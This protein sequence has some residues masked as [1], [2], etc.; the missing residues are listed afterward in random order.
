MCI[1][2]L[3][4]ADAYF[5]GF[6]LHYIFLRLFGVPMVECISMLLYRPHFS[7]LVAIESIMVALML[8]MAL[9]GLFS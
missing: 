3:V 8:A 4:V 5:L 9:L 2:Q 6:S 7:A 1:M